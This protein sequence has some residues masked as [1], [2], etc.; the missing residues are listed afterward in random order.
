MRSWAGAAWTD[1]SSRSKRPLPTPTW[2]QG[3]MYASHSSTT[4][5]PPP[6]PPPAPPLRVSVDARGN[7]RR[8]AWPDAQGS[9]LLQRSVVVPVHEGQ[10]DQPVQPWSQDPVRRA[11]PPDPR[12][13]RTPEG[14]EPTRGGPKAMGKAASA[15]RAYS[16]TRCTAT[17]ISSATLRTD[18]GRGRRRTTAATKVT[19]SGAGGRY[20]YRT[21]QRARILRLATSSEACSWALSHEEHR[22]PR[23]HFESGRWEDASL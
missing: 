14:R 1:H 23:T 20:G 17:A 12:L 8:C 10:Q 6:L 9:D 18:G 3:W 19:S 5:S 4:W 22:R 11:A 13:L 21:A 7:Q 16:W 2:R 15:L